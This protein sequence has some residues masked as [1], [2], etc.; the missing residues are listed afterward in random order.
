MTEAPVD[1][2]IVPVSRKGTKEPRSHTLNFAHEACSFWV[3][4][5]WHC[6]F[7]PGI[8]V[9]LKMNVCYVVYIHQEDHSEKKIRKKG[10]ARPHRV[11]AMEN[12]AFTYIILWQMCSYPCQ[13]LLVCTKNWCWFL[14]HIHLCIYNIRHDMT[15]SWK[16]NFPT[17]SQN[18]RFVFPLNK[19][20]S[21]WWIHSA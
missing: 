20:L 10:N 3:L 14:I 9:S 7:L 5:C 12:F 2:H 17:P 21:H 4:L 13:K 19:V 8:T 16:G 15:S 6:Y 18:A 1:S 11:M